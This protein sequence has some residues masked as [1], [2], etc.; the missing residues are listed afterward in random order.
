MKCRII[1][2]ANQKGGVGKTTSAIN[3][4][5][6]ISLWEKKVLLVDFDPQG[7]STTGLG[8][9]K[10]EE[11]NNIY[12]LITGKCS[13]EQTLLRLSEYLDIIPGGE[14]L[15]AFP[16]EVYNDKD[17]LFILKKLIS[18]LRPG[19]DFIIIDTPP[20]LNLITLNGIIA[21][22][23]L[24]IPVQ[25]E[26]YALEGITQVLKTLKKVKRYT[27]KSV[28]KTHFLV[29]MY[30]M[31]TSIS[32]QVRQELEKHFPS[33]V[34]K[35]VIPRNV[36]IAEAPGFGESVLTYAPLSKGAYAY[37]ELVKEIMEMKI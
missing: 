10:K 16:M 37:K 12:G 4:A 31:R 33:D 34:L 17:R 30:D 7:N 25:A 2:V 13:L 1:D 23:E 22:D 29:T 28:L 21:A 6:G 32:K 9:D 18:E 26:F 11:M 14:D 20:S 36:R 27:G 5:V 24:L 3:L 15:S 8:I 19:Y 35:T